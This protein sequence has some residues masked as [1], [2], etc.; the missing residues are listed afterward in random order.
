MISQSLKN[1]QPRGRGELAHNSV[2]QFALAGPHCGGSFAAGI[3]IF[4]LLP[5]YWMAKSSFQTNT[6]II[7]IPP[8]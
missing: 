7:A 1:A 5:F 4:V 3:V 2:L 8:T 6:E